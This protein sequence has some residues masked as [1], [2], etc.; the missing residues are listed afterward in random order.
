MADDETETTEGSEEEKTEGTDEGAR[1][2]A[3]DGSDD[4]SDS[5]G[6]EDGEESD[7]KT[8]KNA[9]DQTPRSDV[10][11]PEFGKK[12]DEPA[13]DVQMKYLKPLAEHMGEDIPDDMSEADAAAKI[14]EM[15]ENAA[16]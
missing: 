3:S 7:A 4:S 16:S 14:N 1:D 11:D 13:N 6:D 15:Q 2:E 10:D 12:D 8:G 9:E 5:S